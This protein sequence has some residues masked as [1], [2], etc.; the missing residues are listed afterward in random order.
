MR[1]LNRSPFLKES[2]EVTFRSERILIRADQIILWVT[3]TPKRI[4]S[5]NPLP[6]P[7]PVILDTGHTHSFSIRE[8]HLRDWAGIRFDSLPLM[9]TIRDRT[10]RIPL[11]AANVWAYT[12]E[13]HSRDNLVEKPPRNLAA[14]KGIAV[15]PGAFP[16][17]PILGLRA[18]ADNKL[19]LIVN[20]VKREATLRTQFSWWPFAAK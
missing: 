1:L 20:G 6:T 19:V 17:L 10:E 4:T 12:N 8:E 7:F 18:I 11:R 16:R 3:L 13:R 14:P 5:P 15:Y 2:S 9:G